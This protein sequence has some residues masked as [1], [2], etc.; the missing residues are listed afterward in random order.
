LVN[1]EFRSG[2]FCVWSLVFGGISGSPERWPVSAGVIPAETRGFGVRPRYRNDSRGTTS[3]RTR[4]GALR[5]VASVLNQSV[6]LMGVV[7]S[8]I[9]HALA[10]ALWRIPP[11][12][13]T[14][15]KDLAG[16]SETRRPLF[17]SLT[18]CNTRIT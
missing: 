10:D 7:V 12:P 3:P 16:A 15:A 1:P 14:M 13:G 9:K 6:E 18:L 8:L 2:I 11:H 5:L 4:V 17:R